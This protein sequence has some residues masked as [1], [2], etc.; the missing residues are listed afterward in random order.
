MLFTEP[1][2]ALVCLY[3]AFQFGL[4]YT[5]VVASPYIFGTVYGFDLRSQSLSFLGFMTGATLA[6]APLILIDRFV[7][8]PR[9]RLFQEQHQQDQRPL[10]SQ[11]QLEPCSSSHSHQPSPR[12]APIQFPP[13]NR[14]YPSYA[15][16]LALPL[17]LVLFAWLTRSSHPY[18][19]YIVPIV[20]QGFAL[21]SSLLIYAA[22]NLY[23]MD[24]YGPLFGASASG[25]NMLARYTLSA[26]F[27]L[28]ALPMYQKLGVG[29]ATTLLAGIAAA[30][31]PIP[32]A[33][34]RFGGAL[35]AKG[36]WAVSD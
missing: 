25:A 11:L 6:P 26:A 33:L 1:I 4:M 32:W 30:M 21:T 22:A 20:L 31:A 18:V 19:S 35:R 10:Q 16:S 9:L 14:L 15:A 27:P 28:F 8:Q 24:T 13:E 36:K 12:S 17:L 5:Y 2:V 23:M 29:G 7:Y 34:R 3:S